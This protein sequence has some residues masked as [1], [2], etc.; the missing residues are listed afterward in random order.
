MGGHAGAVREGLTITAAQ[1]QAARGALA[2]RQSDLARESG[3]GV[4]TIRNFELGRTMPTKGTLVLL[5]MAF[6]TAGMEFIDPEPSAVDAS[7][8]EGINW[9]SMR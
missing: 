4:V 5:R 7:R 8:R 9:R 1:C 2:W 6:E 3:V